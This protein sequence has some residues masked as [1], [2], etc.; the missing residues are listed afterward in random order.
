[1]RAIKGLVL[2]LGV[3]LLAG[4]GV[5]GYGLYSKAPGKGTPSAALG[6]A[7]AA[8]VAEFG[9]LAVPIPAGS[10]VEQM[11]VAGERVVLRMTGGGPER[12]V[13]LDPNSGKV[14]GGFVLTPEP[15]VR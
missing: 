7:A 9:Q 10:R 14:A 1:M 11:M 12:I 5:L 2:F 15:A 3:L 6:R 4:L 13:V 8:P